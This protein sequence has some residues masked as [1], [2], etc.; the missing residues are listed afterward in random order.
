MFTTFPEK[1]TVIYLD[2]NKWIDLSRAYHGM[3]GGQKFQHVLEKIQTA[4]FS[5][6]AIFPLSFQHYY[7]TNK[8]SD[9]EQRRRLAKVMAEISQGIAISPQ[10]RLMKWELESALAKLFNEPIPETLSVFGY[11]LP[12][13]FGISLAIMNHNGNYTTIPEEQFEQIRDRI[14]SPKATFDLLMEVDNN[15]FDDWTREFQ[16]THTNLVSRLEEFRKKIRKLDRSSRK[17]AYI[18]HLA[19]ALEKK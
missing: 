14:T 18:V 17:H 10:E 16:T 5:E 11:G 13:A 7:E 19:T 15:E 1:T 4:V 9:L 6:S 2:Q 3:P 12:C 8:N